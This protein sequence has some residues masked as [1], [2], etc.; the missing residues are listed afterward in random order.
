MLTAAFLATL[1]AGCIVSALTF[2]LCG[3]RALMGK[4]GLKLPNRAW[5]IAW[6]LLGLS[7]LLCAFTPVVIPG[8]ANPI[9]LPSYSIPLMGAPEPML[10]EPTA[11][12][13][14]VSVYALLSALWLLGALGAL[15]W[16]CV[17]CTRFRRSL[18]GRLVA[19]RS[20]EWRDLFEEETDDLN[21]FRRVRLM[22]CDDIQTPMTIG[23]IRPLLLLPKLPYT[24]EQ[25]R[26]VLRHELVHIRRCDVLLKHGMLLLEI[27]HWYNPA[28]YLLARFFAHDMELSCDE[29]V[30]RE[31]DARA[32]RAYCEALLT[33]AARTSA[34]EMRY[35]TT[36]RNGKQTLRQ[37]MDAILDG[38]LRAGTTPFL[39]S[40]MLAVAICAQAMPVFSV[41]ESAQAETP[42]AAEIILEDE[43]ESL[44]QEA[45]I[46]LVDAT[47][48]P[49]AAPAPDFAVVSN[50]GARERLHLRA[51]PDVNADSLGRYYN[52]VRVHILSREAGE[53]ARVSV[54]GVEGYMM[55][56]Y[57]AFGDAGDAVQI[58]TPM[59]VVHNPNPGDKL[60][61]R[62]RPSE[63]AESLERYS[64]GTQVQVM[65][66]IDGWAHAR[67]GDRTG[68]MMM[69]FLKEVA[70]SVQ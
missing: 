27:F 16:R 59:Y 29:R 17:E 10:T 30:V 2:L 13:P 12:V 41:M 33:T 58:A 22:L 68:Y 51:L 66:T 61:L 37:R 64:N 55:S 67:V 11:V 34:V 35:S 52:G 8:G 20:G 65:G 69:E 6:L 4:I 36:L 14:R 9:R 23:A 19:V 18:R 28:V 26:L 42:I 50:P 49:T 46:V 38:R 40:I 45:D 7:L 62:E 3:L 43:L 25:R 57:L 53:W 63:Q 60:N 70:A 39:L 47:P 54:M 56:A 21:L 24:P 48:Q 31:T 1:R 44:P 32:R 15:I 5:Y